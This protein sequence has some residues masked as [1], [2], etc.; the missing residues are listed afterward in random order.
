MSAVHQYLLPLGIT[1]PSKPQPVAGGY[2]IWVNLPLP[3]RANEIAQRASDEENLIVAEGDLFQVHGDPV[4]N[5]A[6]FERGLRICFA[7]EEVPNL[8]EGV[9]RLGRVVDR[10]L[11]CPERQ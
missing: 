2:F 3:L 8:T 7:W 9:R 4:E 1:L 5:P 10:A 11:R 6:T